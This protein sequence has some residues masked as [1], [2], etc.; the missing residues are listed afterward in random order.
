MVIDLL[1]LMKDFHPVPQRSQLGG[2][3]AQAPLGACLHHH[4]WYKKLAWKTL[5]E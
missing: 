3:A 5:Q 4:P 1:I 2:Q